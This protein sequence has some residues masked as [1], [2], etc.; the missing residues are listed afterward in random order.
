[1]RVVS[2]LYLIFGTL[3]VSLLSVGALTLWSVQSWRGAVDA[4]RSVREQKLEVHRLRGD[5]L[6]QMNEMFEHLLLG[7][8]DSETEVRTLQERMDR[9]LLTLRQAARSDDES[10]L[11]GDLEAADN[12][13]VAATA[14]L[15]RDIA[16][17][18]I[19][20]AS[21]IME[22]KLEAELFPRQLERIEA[23]SAFYR[24]ELDEANERTLAA[25][26]LLQGFTGAIILFMLG[27]GAV[28]LRGLRRWL[29][30]PL[31]EIGHSIAIIGTGNL[32]HRVPVRARDELGSIATEI[33]RMAVVLGDS[34]EQLVASQRLAAV[35]E[36]SSYIAHNIR[37]PLAAMRSAAQLGLADVGD[38]RASRAMLLDIIATVDKLEGWVRQLLGYSG[39]LHLARVP[40]DINGMLRDV[41]GLLQPTLDA[42]R[43]H[44]DFDLAP[45]L[46]R[47]SLDEPHMEQ[48]L[49]AIVSNAVDACHP[50]GTL[51]V[52]TRRTERGTSITIV[53]NGDGMPPAVLQKVFQPY[54]T[55]KPAGVGLGLAMARRIVEA[56]GGSVEI[57]SAA[58]SGTTVTIELLD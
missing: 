50:G 10:A 8:L 52:S 1:M 48:A 44:L 6:L 49:A 3:L 37:N 21:E 30:Q 54:F 20:S 34:Q 42:K 9:R 7:D 53:D 39:P 14:Q 29:V 36:L 4:L 25:N 45:T 2:R 41:L 22:T 32:G 38:A 16:A 58:G 57:A 26:R 35:G 18:R 27:A 31:D 56:H 15:F 11:I 13:I 33:N 23:L 51:N 19:E 47:L 12:A 43:L 5:V 40:S 24:H 55:T 28:L 46:P 17:S